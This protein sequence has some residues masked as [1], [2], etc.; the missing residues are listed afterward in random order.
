MREGGK[1]PLWGQRAQA[2]DCGPGPHS[3]YKTVKCMQ[4]SC[5]HSCAPTCALTARCA[6]ALTGTAVRFLHAHKY[7]WLTHPAEVCADCKMR[8]C[9]HWDRSHR[10]STGPSSCACAC[11]HSCAPQLRL[12]MHTQLRVRSLQDHCLCSQGPQSLRE[13]TTAATMIAPNK[14]A[15][16]GKL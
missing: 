12:C 5:I 9:S 2:R 10:E 15:R 16:V 13:H 6:C 11:I 1:P 3:L 8:L 14:I 7:F 4:R